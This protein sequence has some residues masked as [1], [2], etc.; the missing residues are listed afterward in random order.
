MAAKQNK[1]PSDESILKKKSELA[2]YLQG[3]ANGTVVIQSKKETITSKLALI[4]ETLLP[5]KNQ[6][7]AYSVL[8]QILLEQI[9]LKVST[10]TLRAFCQNHLDFPKSKRAHKN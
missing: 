9:N 5:L 1:L 4:S 7:I 6:G 2:E 8:A 10:Q 3:I